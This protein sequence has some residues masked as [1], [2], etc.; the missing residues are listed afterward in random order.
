YTSSGLYWEL[1]ESCGGTTNRL[2]QNLNYL[3]KYLNDLLG[4]GT[5][6]S[7]PIANP[8][9]WFVGAYGYLQLSLENPGY[10]REVNPG[11]RLDLITGR[12]QELA[13]FLHSLTPDLLT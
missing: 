3:K 13:N 4:Q 9:D 10:F 5:A 6:G 2:D 7:L 12:G 8:R 11:N 1:T